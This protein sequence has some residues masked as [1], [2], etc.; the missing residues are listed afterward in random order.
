MLL[1]NG[2]D[3]YGRSTVS[4]GAVSEIKFISRDYSTFRRNQVTREL[5]RKISPTLYGSNH[6]F[7]L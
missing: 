7:F 3:T 2:S 5:I 1:S 4:F 6:S